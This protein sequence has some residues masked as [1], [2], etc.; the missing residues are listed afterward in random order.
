[1]ARP[2]PRPD[3]APGATDRRLT[4]HLLLRWAQQSAPGEESVATAEPVRIDPALHRELARTGAALDHLLR[5][6]ADGILGG[7]PALGGFSPPEFP[8]AKDIYSVGPLGSPFFWGRFDMF[9]RAGGG[10]AVLEYNCDKPAGQ[11]EMWASSDVGSTRSNPNRHARARFRHALARAWGLPSRGARR[12]PRLAILADPAHREEFRLAYLFGGEASTLGWSWDVVGPENLAVDDGVP[13]AYGERVDIVLRQYPAEYLHELPAAAGLLE[14]AREGRLLWLNDPRAVVA[15]S[16]STF[17][18][19]WALVRGGQWLM[20]REAALVRRVVPP[21]G[22]ASQPGWLERARSRPEDWVLKPVLGRYSESVATGAL[23]SP[24][25]WQAALDA[26]AASPGEWIVQAF[27]PPGRRWLP[28]PG[29]A[30]P[31]YVN[32]G[33]YLTDGEVSGLCPRLQPTPLTEEGTTWWAPPIVRR[34]PLTQPIVTEPSRAAMRGEGPGSL[35]RAIAD[36]LALQGYT[37]TWTDGFANFSLAA[38][39]LSTA[40]W[41]ELRHAT[42]VLG[43]AVGRALAHMAARPELLS[44]LG[45]P[46]SLAMLAAAVEAPE[47]WSFLSRFDWARTLDGRWKLLEINSDTPAGLWETGSVE[48][49]VARLHRASWRPSAGFWPALASTW[50][51]WVDHK[52]GPTASARS[53]R[54][55]L[56][57][58]LASPEDQDQLRAHTQAAR[59][60]MPRAS[61]EI[62]TPDD[63]RIRS[64]RAMLGGRG[65]DLVFRYYPL[66]WL[67]E[68]RFAPLLEA[69]GSGTLAMLPPAHVLIPQSKAFVALAWELEAQGFFPPTEAAAVRQYVAPTALTPEPLGRRPYVIKPYLEREGRGVRFSTELSSRERRRLVDGPVVCQ[70]RLDVLSARVSVATARGWTRERRHLIFGVF[71]TGREITG[72]Y[73][74]A[75]ARITGREAVYLPAVLRTVSR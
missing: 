15:Q 1:M 41:D 35:W 37:N 40:D 48:A 19:L 68:P 30:R 54:I 18:A 9:E 36:R 44:V 6:L 25:D 33:V 24:R 56:V 43:K 10:L 16:K 50:R 63:L 62:G 73:T 46:P 14:A 38:I 75:G 49:E 47:D 60:A 70:E 52:L 69:V 53:L 34:E 28:A 61:I 26:A 3:R 67:A 4:D 58:V 5:R 29:G 66:E 23:S 20:R 64:G 39:E 8:L 42:L 65:V 11:R 57:G 17:A 2:A 55:G 59:E 13:L 22:L 31:G 71:L 45:I 72:I 12:R 7:D 74:R 51:R 32:W 21:T 27:V